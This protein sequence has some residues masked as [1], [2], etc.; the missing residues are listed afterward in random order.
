ML[1]LN[2]GSRHFCGDSLASQKRATPDYLAPMPDAFRPAVLRFTVFPLLIA[3]ATAIM[4]SCYLESI[5]NAFHFCLG[6]LCSANFSMVMDNHVLAPFLT[7]IFPTDEGDASI[8]PPLRKALPRFGSRVVFQ[9][10]PDMTVTTVNSAIEELQSLRAIECT[11]FNLSLI[12]S[13]SNSVSDP[14][15]L[16]C[17][18]QIASIRWGTVLNQRSQD[19][20]GQVAQRRD[21][22]EAIEPPTGRRFSG[23]VLLAAPHAPHGSVDD[24]ERH[25]D[26]IAQP[27]NHGFLNSISRL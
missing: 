26:N 15:G 4:T 24:E 18:P 27:W 16:P 19:S 2:L 17:G 21:P 25:P 20:G 3:F 14:L 23:D 7:G 1:G 13:F 8:F 12:L 22:D 6:S 10:R 11:D 9:L 5:E